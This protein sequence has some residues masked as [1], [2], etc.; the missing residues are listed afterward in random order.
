LPPLGSAGVRISPV[1]APVTDFNQAVLVAHNQYRALHAVAPL[2]IS[3]KLNRFAQ[4]WADTSAKR[5]TMEHRPNNSYGEN[6]YAKW[7]SKPGHTIPGAEAVESWY[8]EIKDHVFG[9]EPKSMATGHFTQLV[10]KDSTHVGIGLARAKKSGK[11][12][13]VCNYEPAGNFV[14]QFAIKVPPPSKKKWVFHQL[15]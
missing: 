4:D 2:Q 9:R 12:Y 6:L 10:W 7:N 11:L 3:I 13:V 8:S 14:G 1:V 5:D 15:E